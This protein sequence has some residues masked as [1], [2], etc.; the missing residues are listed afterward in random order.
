MKVYTPTIANKLLAAI[1]FT[2]SL[3]ALA[4]NMNASE[5]ARLAGKPSFSIA[6]HITIG[7]EIKLAFDANTPGQPNLTLHLPNGASLS[8]GDAISLGDFYAVIGEPISKGETEAERKRRF[9]A[10]FDSFART[11][12]SAA[13]IAK[14]GSIARQELK[15]LNERMKNGETPEAIYKSLSNETG[16]QLNCATGGGCNKNTWWLQPGRYMTVARD[17]Y[18]H[19]GDNAIIAY[20]T[21]HQAAI[22][23][24]LAAHKTGDHAQLELAYA[25][26]AFASHYLSD[27]FSAGHIRTP[28][29]ALAEQVTPELVGAL[30]ASYMHSEE[31]AYGLHVHNQRND[32]WVA[33]GDWSY[34]NKLNAPAKPIIREALQVSTDDIFNAYLYGDTEDTDKTMTYIPVADEFNTQNNLDISPLF[35]WDSDNNVLMRRTNMSD[36]YSHDWTSNW[37]GWSTLAELREERG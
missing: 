30:L 19:F 32:H 2:I 4:A 23:Q 16:R 34:F 3:P 36:P 21:G 15:I 20:Q 28:R 35:Y 33:Y 8:Y 13:E 27:R 22:E 25:M 26:N 14:L 31:N 6:E 10:A 1:I 5:I 24:A 9:I 17:N 11:P 18:D 12:E 37:W 7:D 29:N